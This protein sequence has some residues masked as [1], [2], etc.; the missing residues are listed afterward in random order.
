MVYIYTNT[1]N[2]R[3][4]IKSVDAATS[5]FARFIIPLPW[6]IASH[7]SWRFLQ[8]WI[9]H[10]LPG[11]QKLLLV[12]GIHVRSLQTMKS[13]LW[14]ILL[15]SYKFCGITCKS[16]LYCW[17]RNERMDFSLSLLEK[18]SKSNEGRDWQI[19]LLWRPSRVKTEKLKIFILQNLLWA[20]LL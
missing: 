15:K 14:I 11:E 7:H 3:Y 18:L 1:T 9:F 5:R 19:A 12:I 6:L 13:S 20:F 2:A 16:A 10:C 8:A 17:K 4:G